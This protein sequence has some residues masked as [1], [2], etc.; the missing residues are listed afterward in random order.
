MSTSPWLVPVTALRRTVGA[1][2]RE[3][4]SGQLGELRVADTWVADDGTA[5]VDVVL[6]VVV[7][8]IEAAGTVSARWASSCRRCLRPVGGTVEAP[9]REL[10]RPGGGADEDTYPLGTDQL[11]LEP[12]ARDALLLGL[13]LAPLCREDCRGICPACGADRSVTSCDC[14]V[15][16]ADPRWGPLDALSSD[17]G[18]DVAGSDD[19]GADAGA[20]EAGA[21]GGSQGWA[22]GR[23]SSA[24]RS[25]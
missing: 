10:Y 3:Q 6:S 16:R 21:P 15:E 4:R 8:G 7:G 11:D 1:R 14:E 17:P 2:Q 19:A 5:T 25:D 23:W 18:S 20:N 13:P 9:V 24:E 12:L 22:P